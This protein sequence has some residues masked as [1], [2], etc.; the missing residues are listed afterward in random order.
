MRMLCGTQQR[1]FLRKVYDD[2]LLENTYAL[3]SFH[4]DPLRR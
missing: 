2:S 3:W 4:V 1:I